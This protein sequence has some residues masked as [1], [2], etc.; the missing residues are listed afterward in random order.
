MLRITHECRR[1]KDASREEIRMIDRRSEKLT[2][3]PGTIVGALQEPMSNSLKTDDE[4]DL[5]LV[6]SVLVSNWRLVAVVTSITTLVSLSI[7]L[8]TT[9]VFRVEVL[10]APAA[11]EGFGNPLI[12]QFGDLASLAGVSLDGAG[13]MSKAIA[14]LKSRSLTDAF[15]REEGLMQVLFSTKWDAKNKKWKTNDKEIP[16]TWDAF[17]L[18]DKEIR[19]VIEDKKTGLLTLTIEWKDPVL[20]AQ[21]ANQLVIRANAQLQRDAINEGKKS[22]TFLKSE[23]AQTSALEVQQ[24]MY[25]LIEAET[26]NIAVAHAREEYAFKVIDPAVA[27][28][29]PIKPKRALLIGAG[30]VLGLMAGVVAA[31]LRAGFQLT[32]S[33]SSS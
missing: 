24:A 27:S 15:I 31:F 6:W 22:I 10:L 2:G 16:T 8:L 23:L 26:K 3:A 14:T 32:K 19:S 5:R 28:K 4:V 33:A 21:W 7:A 30:L 29:K 25:R 12:S 17:E 9:P 13:A 18:F 20:A 1:T 11:K